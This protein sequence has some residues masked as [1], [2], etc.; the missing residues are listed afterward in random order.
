MVDA[1]NFKIYLL[2]SSKPMANRKKKKGR[3]K[4]KNLNILRAKRVF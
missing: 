4:Y 2:S 1:I 3:Q